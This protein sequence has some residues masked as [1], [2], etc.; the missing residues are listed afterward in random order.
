[1]LENLS[2][3]SGVVKIVKIYISKRTSSSC[4]S[5]KRIAMKSSSVMSQVNTGTENSYYKSKRKC[6]LLLGVFSR[7]TGL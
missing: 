3:R 7:V 5:V 1:M 6:E 2:Y 4:N